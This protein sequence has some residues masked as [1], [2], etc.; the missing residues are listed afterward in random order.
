ME[1]ALVSVATGALKPVM[2][3]LC[4]LLGDEYNYF[5]GVR[6]DVKSLTHEL[7]A[8]DAFLM[9]MSEEEDPDEQDKVWMNEVRELSYDMEDC[10]DDFMQS[11]DDKDTKPDGF[12]EKIKHSLG[13]MKARHRIG[14]EI[15]DLKKQIIEVGE[16]NQRYKTREVFSN[17]N[18]AISNKNGTF[19]PRAL[20]I[21]EDASKLVGIDEPKAEIVK[22]LTEGASTQEQPKL[23]SIVGSGGMGKTTLANQV[24]Q[25]LKG[26]FDCRAFLSVS[27]NPD[28]M[29]ILRTIFSEVTGKDYATTEAGSIEQLIRKIKV[30]LADKR[31]LDIATLLIERMTYLC[32]E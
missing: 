24:Y 30:F 3:K 19:D 9:K 23:V 4:A 1:V 32:K 8:M 12:I 29:I 20:A 16:R 21:F 5:K 13:K 14:N 17:T 2:W 22:L 26:K 25:Y 10:I 31:I 7:A 6:K 15:H 18:N 28:M 27:R 11:L